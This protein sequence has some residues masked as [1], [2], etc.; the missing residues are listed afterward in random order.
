MKNYLTL[1]LLPAIAL[2]LQGCKRVH[3][4]GYPK[5]DTGYLPV[6]FVG[7]TMS[8]IFNDDTVLLKVVPPVFSESYDKPYNHDIHCEAYAQVDLISSDNNLILSYSMNS[9]HS[10]SVCLLQGKNYV[11]CGCVDDI[12]D[13]WDN[14]SRRAE[15]LP[16]WTSPTGYTYTDVV[17][18]TEM[19]TAIGIDTLYLSKRYGLLHW[20]IHGGHTLTLLP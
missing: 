12:Y 13:E 20:H 17:K 14:G 3:C 8:Y 10:L 6:D 1:L 4:P 18:S 9:W 11:S 16:Q 5:S 7:Q 19:I 15:D 2:L